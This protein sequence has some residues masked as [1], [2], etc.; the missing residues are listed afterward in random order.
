LGTVDLGT[1]VEIHEHRFDTGTVTINYAEG[2][3]SGPPLV[4]LHGGTAHW[5]YYQEVLPDLAARLSLYAPDFRGHGGSGRVPGRYRFQDYADDI[6]AFLRGC[7]GER[8]FLFGHSLGGSIALMVAAQVP[9]LVR[10]L[11]VGDSLLTGSGFG[12]ER[13]KIE[14]WRDLAGAG[15]RS[16]RSPRR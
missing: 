14:A 4:W 10:A 15:C 3:P 13:A 6:V 9:D 2:P 8:A 16:K 1:E 5:Q 12:R 7:V 11:V